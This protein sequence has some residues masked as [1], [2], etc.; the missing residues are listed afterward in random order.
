MIFGS[1][2]KTIIKFKS[3]YIL[4]NDMADQFMMSKQCTMLLYA[5]NLH[6]LHNCNVLKQQK[7]KVEISCMN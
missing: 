6:I 5:A 3:G 1:Y 4:E 7:Y 2:I